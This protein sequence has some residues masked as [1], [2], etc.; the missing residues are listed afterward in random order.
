MDP[1]KL[2][3]LLAKKVINQSE[4]DIYLVFELFDLGRNLLNNMCES[5]LLEE[6]P[7]MKGVTF[8]WHDGRR[9]TWRH[10]K[11]IIMKVETLLTKEDDNDR[12][13]DRNNHFYDS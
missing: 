9:S 10:I 3:D 7:D 8:A 6:P 5:V 4:Y 12:V 13:S 1:N 2:K 11:M